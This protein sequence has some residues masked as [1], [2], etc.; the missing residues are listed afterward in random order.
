MLA[1]ARFKRKREIMRNG[2]FCFEEFSSSGVC[3]IV[4]EWYEHAAV[5]LVKAHMIEYKNHILA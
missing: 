2:V 5:Q 1:P 3:S 4:I